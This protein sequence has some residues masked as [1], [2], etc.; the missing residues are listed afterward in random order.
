[1]FGS[2]RQYWQIMGIIALLHILIIAASNYLVQFPFELLGFNTTWGAYTYPLIFLVTDLTVRLFGAPLARRIVFCV[3][4]PGLLISYLLTVLFDDGAF[5]GWD[6]L[7]TPNIIALRVVLASFSAYLVG[8]LMDIFIF[9]RLMQL[10]QWW[11]A[12]AASAIFGTLVD[13]VVFFSIAFAGST[14]AFMASHWPE[15]ATV[16]Y[17]YKLLISLVLLLSLY[18]MLLSW[19]QTRLLHLTGQAP[20]PLARDG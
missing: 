14:D 16:D 1:M 9:R 6:S 17:I 5:A 20:E 10:P 2:R 12:P 11:I 3:M 7:F 13:T 19:L 8:Q 18:G 15:I 4:F